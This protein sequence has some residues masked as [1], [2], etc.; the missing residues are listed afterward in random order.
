MYTL[1][2]KGNLL[3]LFMCIFK[4][5]TCKLIYYV[6]SF[7]F[8]KKN[9]N[10]NIKWNL[11]QLTISWHLKLHVFHVFFSF[12]CKIQKVI[13]LMQLMMQTIM[14]LTFCSSKL[15]DY[16]CSLLQH[17]VILI[18]KENMNHHNISQKMNRIKNN[19]GHDNT[20][21]VFNQQQLQ[22]QHQQQQQ[23]QQKFVGMKKV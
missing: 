22:K 23:Q 18:Q 4:V 5:S 9:K 11:F 13:L 12:N 2:W 10:I 7:G 20:F 14:V 17:E 8:C 21:L 3:S 1:K 15:N 16:Y 19:N 6:T